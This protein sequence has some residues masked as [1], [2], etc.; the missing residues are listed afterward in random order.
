MYSFQKK[1]FA[2]ILIM[3]VTPVAGYATK[4]WANT[5]SFHGSLFS[6]NT[7]GKVVESETWEHGSMYCQN[8]RKYY[9]LG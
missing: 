8:L 5:T 6:E 3:Q 2:Y 7:G 4:D 9:F 1:Y